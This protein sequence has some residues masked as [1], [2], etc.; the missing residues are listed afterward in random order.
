MLFE[1]RVFF[2]SEFIVIS[3]LQEHIV[4]FTVTVSVGRED[5]LVI[6]T[7][8]AHGYKKTK[9]K[10]LKLKQNK[11]GLTR[12]IGLVL[13]NPNWK[14]LQV[15][16]EWLQPATESK[17]EW[18][19][20]KRQNDLTWLLI[21]NYYYYRHQLFL[22]TKVTKEVFLTLGSSLLQ[23]VLFVLYLPTQ[24][25]FPSVPNEV[26]QS[27]HPTQIFT[28]GCIPVFKS[29]ISVL[30]CFKMPNAGLEIGQKPDPEK[31]IGYPLSNWTRTCHVPCVSFDEKTSLTMS[32]GSWI[33]TWPGHEQ[34]TCNRGKSMY[35]SRQANNDFFLAFWMAKKLIERRAAGSFPCYSTLG[36]SKLSVFYE[37]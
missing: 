32:L 33:R 30:F 1:K 12:Q 28:Q 34:A 23:L 26:L 35:P 4:S 3:Q 24:S 20:Q 8:N 13:H 16:I 11:R 19:V 31:P 15:S 9:N 37:A 22:T 17:K 7:I 29:Q 25:C 18:S 27:R 10:K 14:P 36:K 2:A 5:I 21:I 6:S